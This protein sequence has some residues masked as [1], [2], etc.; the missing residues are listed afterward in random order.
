[1]ARGPHRFESSDPRSISRL[2]EIEIEK[3]KRS[4]QRYAHSVVDFDSA[5][6][7]IV[8]VLAASPSQGSRGLGPGATVWNRAQRCMRM[9]G[10]ITGSLGL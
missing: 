3:T 1:V 2:I 8:L 7:L 6:S 4:L 9:A 10:G 5:R